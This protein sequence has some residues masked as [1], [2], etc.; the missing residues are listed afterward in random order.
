MVCLRSPKKRLFELEEAVQWRGYIRV[1]WYELTV[2]IREAEKLLYV[3]TI[4]RF[5]PVQYRLY[6]LWVHLDP[7]GRYN[8][9][10]ELNFLQVKF[11]FLQLGV[12][13]VFS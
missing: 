5:L 12:E 11:T 2:I 6:L 9:I 3:L 1:R 10:Q 13:S 8:V 7:L 4:P